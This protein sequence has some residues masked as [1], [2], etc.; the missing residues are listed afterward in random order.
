M[1]FMLNPTRHIIKSVLTPLEAWFNTPSKP[2]IVYGNTGVGKTSII[3]FLA[4]KHSIEVESNDNPIKLLS[5]ARHPSFDGNY[6]LALIEG[7][8][9]L[10]ASQYNAIL[11]T[12]NP[13][14]Y[15][16]ECEFLESIPYKL[17][18]RCMVVEIPKP[19]KRFLIA[20][21]TELNRH[22][23]L[24][25]AD[26]LIEKISDKAESWRMA[27]FCLKYG[28]EPNRIRQ[29]VPDAKQPA[30][31]LKQGYDYSSCHPLSI[32]QM[33]IHNKANPTKCLEALRLYS[34]GWEIDDLTKVSRT[35][36]EQLRTDT[37]YKPPFTRRKLKGSNK[38][39]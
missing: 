3:R 4:N 25:V 11:K 9:Y 39:L 36:L 27:T 26:S 21:L 16:L 34:M 5:D 13:P 1:I 8:D 15:I 24:N 31:I 20:G 30:I 37:T 23:G 7:A 22:L 12:D 29:T 6:R 10:K 32:I 2:L 14:P 19:A 35:L 28:I 38:R 17:R 33:A 18:Q